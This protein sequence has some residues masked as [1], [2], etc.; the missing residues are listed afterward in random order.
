MAKVKT[1]ERIH[2]TQLFGGKTTA[3][4][5]HA[6]LA[7]GH[8][9]CTACKN[10][11]IVLV[12]RLLAPLKE[13]MSTW[14]ELLGAMKAANG[15]TIPRVETKF[16]PLVKISEVAACTMCRRDAEKVAA[17]APSWC[18]IE[19]DRGPGPENASVSVH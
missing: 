17:K 18:V 13:C 11:K 8:K 5:L 10:K 7:W 16:G 19:F 15:G 3:E 14:P 6:K 1:T 2:R 4:E 12:V 9:H